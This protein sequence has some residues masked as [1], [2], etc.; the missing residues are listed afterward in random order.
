MELL[1]LRYFHVVARLEHMTR[2][3]EELCIAQPSLSKT[4]RRLE[5]ELGVP[6][7]ERQGRSVRLNQF[8]RAF[9][10][11]VEALLRELA[12]GQRK[13]RD[14]VGLEHGAI[15]LAAASLNWLPEL[16][17]RF[18]ASHPAVQFQLARRTPAEMPH[19]LESGACDFCFQ[20]T[21]LLKPGIEWRP[22][23]TH[24]M[25]LVVAAEH[26]FAKLHNIPLC[27]M[28]DEAVVI[29]KAGHGLRDL[30]DQFCHQAGFTPR[31]VFEVDEPAAI[32]EFVRANLGVAFAPA[33][34]T[35][36]ID[37]LGLVALRLTDPVC[38]ITFGIAWHRAHYLSE[39]ARAFRHFVVESFSA[40][41]EAPPTGAM[42]PLL[43]SSRRP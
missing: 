1:Q 41:E 6:L 9:L 32:F 22:L 30:V 15:S 33:A 29:E 16:L 12:E 28:A 13:V 21:P 2:A 40:R 36:Q 14:M 37:A 7:F 43:E 27:Q 25:L 3:A 11:H 31:A 34:V 20:S 35:K 38:R 10:E 23:L 24:E 19:L 4:I 17:H 39:A 18:Q 8:G 42:P 5:Q 26:R